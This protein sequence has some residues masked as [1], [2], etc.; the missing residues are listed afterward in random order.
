MVDPASTDADRPAY[1]DQNI[2]SV[3]E[4]RKRE[5]EQRSA[6][7][8]LVD[9]VSRIIGRPLYLLILVGFAGAWIAI[10]VSA[11]HFGRAAF[12]PS[13]FPLLDGILSL[14]ALIT[15]TVVLIAQNR[16]TRIEQ[17]HMHISL[18]VNLVTE[19]KVAKII[20]LLEELRRDLPMVKD[21]YDPKAA[22]Y[23]Q[24]TD[25]LQVL[26]AIEEVGL[27]KDPAESDVPP[28][29]EAAGGPERKTP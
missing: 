6:A 23:A 29:G 24:E 17:Q 11:A 1:L 22:S 16:Q 5:R 12:D 19:Q 26:T 4:V 27:T 28:S 7:H 21:R 2:D 13:P 9:R 3:L 15:T 8:R 14:A 10:N 20:N 25:A 18:Q